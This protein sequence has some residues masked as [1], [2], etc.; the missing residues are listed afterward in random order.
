MRPALGF[1]QVP[2]IVHLLG[3]ELVQSL[4]TLLLAL[5]LLLRADPIRLQLIPKI[6]ADRF[7]A[8]TKSRPLR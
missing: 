3:G 5:S 2:L 1:D 6:L 7:A 8:S 4:L